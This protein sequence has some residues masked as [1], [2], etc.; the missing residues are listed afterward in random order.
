MMQTAT[1]SKCAL[2]RSGD[3]LGRA[4]WR[5]ELNPPLKAYQSTTMFHMKEMKINK[6]K[7]RLLKL[8][9][10]GNLLGHL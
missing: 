9:L 5:K 7:I 1:Y 2:R 10:F 8:S 3:G 4:G 6:I